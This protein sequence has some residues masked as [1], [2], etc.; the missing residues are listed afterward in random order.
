ML[1]TKILFGGI[2]AVAMSTASLPAFAAAH[3]SNALMTCEEFVALTP[4][5]RQAAAKSL[6]TANASAGT[7]D[8]VT[9]SEADG[10]VTSTATTGTLAADS[11]P[12]GI[13]SDATLNAD[14]SA[15]MDGT[16]P[17]DQSTADTVAAD[18]SATVA[19]DSG[20]TETNDAAISIADPSEIVVALL[21]ICGN[22]V[23]MN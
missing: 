10:T 21:T 13:G 3:T 23:K 7:R 1:R 9:T 4:M 18:T 14:G 19:S 17:T 5:E 11:P 2:S 12:V 20:T 22:T 8:A 16:M 6:S 15:T